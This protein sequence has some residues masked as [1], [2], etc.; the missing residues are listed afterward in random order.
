MPHGC[1]V[2]NH[3]S[4]NSV[5]EKQWLFLSL[6]NGFAKSDQE[7][8]GLK[9]Y[10]FFVLSHNASHSHIITALSLDINYVNLFLCLF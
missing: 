3:S 2:T 9:S 10:S 6:D 7:H 8:L 1:H 4:E 5:L